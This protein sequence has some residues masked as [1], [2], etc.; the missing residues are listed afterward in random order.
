MVRG[1]LIPALLAL[2]AGVLPAAATQAGWPALFDV[3]G[4]ASDDVLNVRTEPGVHGRIIGTLPP[5]AT[6]VEVIMPTDDL[7]WGMVNVDGQSGWASMNFLERVSM[8]WDGQF[9]EI[10]SCHGTEPFWNLTRTDGEVALN[11]LDAEAVVSPP[12]DWQTG[13]INH[14]GR[15]AFRG[16]DL[17]GVVSKQ[18]CSDGMSDIRYG[19][20]LNLILLSEQTHYQGCCT[21]QPPAE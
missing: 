7:T 17:L 20:E 16:G 10:T 12:I 21:I 14:R 6:N 5:D 9:P 8:N 13:A 4:V 2:L 19:L 1:A 18:L 15:H 3:T 11:R